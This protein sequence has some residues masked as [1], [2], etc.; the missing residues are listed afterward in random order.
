MHVIRSTTCPNL[1]REVVTLHES[2]LTTASHNKRHIL[3]TDSPSVFRWS[4]KTLLSLGGECRYKPALPTF[5]MTSDIFYPHDGIGT[6]LETDPR[7][8]FY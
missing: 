5:L 3:R 6:H 7:E 4:T 1:H 2:H 8:G